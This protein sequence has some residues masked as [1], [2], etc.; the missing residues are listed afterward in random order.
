M[1]ISSINVRLRNSAPLQMEIADDDRGK[2][3][4]WKAWISLCSHRPWCNPWCERGRG[5]NPVLR[6]P[7]PVHHPAPPAEVLK[8]K[9]T[10]N[11]TTF[12]RHSAPNSKNRPRV[13]WEKKGDWSVSSCSFLCVFLALFSVGSP[14]VTDVNQKEEKKNSNHALIKRW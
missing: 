9:K 2:T 12:K 5:G 11:A 3:P 14:S 6:L 4:T 10:K 1:A 13:Q 8:R 7:L